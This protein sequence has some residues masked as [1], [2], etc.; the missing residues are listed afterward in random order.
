VIFRYWMPLVLPLA[1]AVVMHVGL[2][3]YLVVFEQ[4]ERR[5]VRSIFTKVVSPDV[6]TELL[7]TDLSLKGA[8]RN[9]TVFFSD[10]RGFTEMTDVNRAKAEEYIAENKLVDAAADEIRNKEAEET[11][12]TVNQYLE[13]IANMVLKNGGTVDKFIGDCVMAFWGAPVANAHHALHC[14]R[15]AID[16]QRAVYK[17]NHEREVINRQREGENL[18]LAA[19]GKPLHPML[20]VLVVGTGINTGVVTVGLMGSDERVNYTVFGREVNL[21]SRLETVSGRARIIISEATLAEIIQDDPAL[22]L[23][24]KALPPEKVK[25][26]REAVR[27]YEVPWREGE[28]LNEETQQL[29]TGTTVYNTG[30]FTAAERTD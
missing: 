1:G 10:I 13:I 12:R 27:I 23:T 26:I 16:T 28:A 5:R 11:L 17:L 30:Y 22:A 18:M 29:N 19:Y 14:V 8:Q 20:P 25:G 2:I 4:A 3:G 9:V 24:C 7:N 6:V 21:A 15:A